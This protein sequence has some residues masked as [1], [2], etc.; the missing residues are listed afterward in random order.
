MLNPE[1][2]SVR[3]I[4]RS[5]ALADACGVQEVALE[6]TRDCLSDAHCAVCAAAR[7]G[8]IRPSMIETRRTFLRSGAAP[9]LLGFLILAGMIGAVLSF[10]AS[11]QDNAEAI[12]HSME[13]ERQLV[14]MLAI[15][16]DAETG[17][18]GYLLTGDVAYLDPYRSAVGRFDTQL[19]MLRSLLAANPVQVRALEGFQSG[20]RAK[21]DELGLTIGRYRVGSR[22]EALALV[23]TG[24]GKSYMDQ[25]R[26]IIGRMIATEDRTQSELRARLESAARWLKIGLIGSGIMYLALAAFAA[27][28]SYGQM[29]KLVASRDALRASNQKLV[30]E[31][32]RREALADQLRQSQKMEAIGQLTGGLAHDFN[33][34]LSV[35]IGS[36]NLLSRRLARGEVDF[37][38]YIDSALD[39]ANRAATLTHRLLAFSRQQP[40]APKSLDINKLVAGMSD[41]L[42]R[43][44]GEQI[45]VETVLA[46]GLWRTRVDPG[47]LE[48]AIL[49]LAVN[50]RDAMP[51]GGR[52]TIETANCHLDDAYASAHVEVPAG[53]YVLVAVTDNGVGMSPAALAKAFDPFFTTKP[54]GKGTGLGLSQVH[55][56]VKQSGGHVKIY[57][58]PG[59][60]TTVKLYLPRFV[61][62]EQAV[63]ARTLD[64]PIPR[65]DAGKLILVV[66][67]DDRA[68]NVTAESLREL[69]YS[70]VHAGG[71][72]SA[73][74]ILDAQPG[75]NLLFTDI[76]MPDV[77]GRQLAEEA[78]RRVPGIKV[79]YTTGYTPNAIVHNGV[80]DPGVQLI[81]KPFTLEQLA[82]KVHAVLESE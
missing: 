13:A 64:R 76:V 67:D 41:L 46:G 2:A 24:A 20:A 51:D 62:A 32:A 9:L 11:E 61:G 68:R 17:Q 29:A 15:L 3:S 44:I 14:G 31:A 63:P 30:E 47:E 81:S 52:L 42:G 7:T 79:L 43:T 35:I 28:N 21:L 23:R 33:N 82:R 57:S 4:P 55:G 66:E 16:A 37:G 18:R 75:V 73:L 10:V 38:K 78:V 25:A 72:A 36:L 58:E 39:G 65:G 19:D 77:N 71:A 48:S 59:Q 45:R 56:F 50:A 40:L 34:M 53:Q 27:L 12:R 22:D 5:V 49:N 54:V 70:V 6:I 74:A 26:E 8:E 60:G 80:V 1:T 69:G